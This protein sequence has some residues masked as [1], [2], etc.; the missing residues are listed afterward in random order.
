MGLHA[1][2]EGSGPRL[3]LVHGFAQTHACWG[4][5]AP[6]LSADHEVVRVDAPGHGGSADVRDDLVSTADLL[7]DA[8][9]P[10]TYLG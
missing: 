3:V 10:A 2:V 4:D 1:V 5:V 9:G 6:V 7:A 8:G